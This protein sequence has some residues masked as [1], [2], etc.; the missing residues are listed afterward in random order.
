MINRYPRLPRPAEPPGRETRPMPDTGDRAAFRP[1]RGD[2]LATWAAVEA[3]GRL[4]RAWDGYK[5]PAPDTFSIQAARFWLAEHQADDPY[6]DRIAPAVVG[7]IGMTYRG[8]DGPRRAY[9]E[10]FNN[11]GTCVLLSD[12]TTDPR[13]LRVEF[14]PQP[15]R[16]AIRRIGA[17]LAVETTEKEGP[18]M[19]TR[20]GQPFFT[21]GA[22]FDPHGM[23]DSVDVFPCVLDPSIVLRFRRSSDYGSSRD[24]TPAEAREIAR[25]LTEAAEIVESG[26]YRPWEDP[27]QKAGVRP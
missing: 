24:L 23:P 20:D 9:V 7:G 17:Y 8:P 22:E 25:A 19:K 12:G 27:G 5:A 11:G 3:F 14:G 26:T 16:D 18:G 10:F 13:T 4:P 15:Y 2:W 1:T 21:L 6:P